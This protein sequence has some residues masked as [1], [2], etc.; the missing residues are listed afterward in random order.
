MPRDGATIF[1]DLIGKLD[2]LRASP[3][4]SAG[5]MVV[6]AWAVSSRCVAAMPSSSNGSMN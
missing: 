2:V 5:A 4:T 1:S 3:A 6:T